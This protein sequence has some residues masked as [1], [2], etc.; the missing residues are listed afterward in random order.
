MGV[1]D[2]RAVVFFLKGVLDGLGEVRVVGVFIRVLESRGLRV[3]G[4]GVRI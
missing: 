1:S 3:Q 4:L 2:F